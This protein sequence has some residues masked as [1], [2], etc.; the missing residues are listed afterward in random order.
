MKIEYIY[1]GKSTISVFILSITCR[2]NL[3]ALKICLKFLMPDLCVWSC[4]FLSNSMN[5]TFTMFSLFSANIYD[6]FYCRISASLCVCLCV[7]VC[8]WV[9]CSTKC[10]IWWFL[11]MPHMPQRRLQSALGPDNEGE[12][13]FMCESE[14]VRMGVCTCVRGTINSH[15]SSRNHFCCCYCC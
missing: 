13:L 1:I 7:Y 15:R 11:C 4:N 2:V 5:K 6:K 3:W 9:K 14:R 10:D 12:R 8:V